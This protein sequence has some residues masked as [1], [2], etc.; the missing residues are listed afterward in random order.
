MNVMSE[1]IHRDPP[2]RQRR[3]EPARTRRQG[4]PRTELSELELTVRRAKRRAGHR[5]AFIGHLVVYGSVCL[6][7]LVVAGF[8]PAVIVALSW[9]IGVLLHGF[10]AV[11]A[12]V[13]RQRWV[14]R[15]VG[16]RLSTRVTHERRALEGRHARAL[17][18]LSASVA[19]EIRNPVTAAKSLVQQIAEDPTH[20]GNAEYAKVAVTE[21]DRV[22]RSV[23][24]LLRYAREEPLSLQEVEMQDIVDAALDVLRERLNRTSTVVD[25]QIEANGWFEADPDKLRRVLI[26]LISNA[27]DALDESGFPSPRIELSSGTNLAGDELWLSVRDNGPGIEAERLPKVF[28]PFH[29]SKE[30]GTGL[31]LAITRKLVEAH[32]GSIEVESK[33]G[34]GACFHL[35]FP[36]HAP[37][38]AA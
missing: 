20:A 21:L 12:P 13:L 22:E 10:F 11:L 19:H 38:G 33:L 9:G 1:R 14:E 6:F 35:V 37:A 18:Q 27:L 15:E 26:N 5:I 4:R 2:V 23:S 36:R 24:H 28:D 16:Q 29:T 3:H 32:G 7:L 34:E 30:Q 31:G 8:F 25:K 17:D